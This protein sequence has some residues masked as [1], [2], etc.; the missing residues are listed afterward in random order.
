MFYSYDRRTSR[1]RRHRQRGQAKLKSKRYYRQKRQ[2]IKNRSKRWR[3][4]N[5]TKVKRYQKRRSRN[6][7]LYKLKPA[8]SASE[9]HGLFQPEEDIYLL[10]NEIEFEDPSEGTPDVG[11]VNWIDLDEAEVHT[12]FVREDGS[13]FEKTYELYDF[14]DKASLMFEEDEEVLLAALDELHEEA[15]DG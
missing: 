14:M 8:R 2:Q 4:Q 7:Q 5:K 12:I 1:E 3:K 10:E 11:F 15:E 6:P 13:R 9:S